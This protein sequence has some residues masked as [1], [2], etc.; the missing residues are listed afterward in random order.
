MGWPSL[1]SWNDVKR[2]ATNTYNSGVNA[3]RQT[4]QAVVNTGRAA[5][6]TV[7]SYARPVLR[8][9]ENLARNG[10]DIGRQFARNPEA[11]TR[12]LVSSA[13]RTV[14]EANNSFQREVR[15]LAGTARQK[16][17]EAEKVAADA[18]WQGTSWTSKKIGQGADV[19]RGQIKGNDIV[20]RN[21][22]GAVTALETNARFTVGAAGGVTR[23]VVGLATS[24]GS[25]GVTAA[26]YNL[27]SQ[28]RNEINGKIAGAA[29]KG[30]AQVADYG[31]S[32]A[33]DP[34]RLVSDLKSTASAA[35]N[36]T[37]DFVGGHL[38]RYDEAIKRGEGAETIGWDVGR[39]GSNFIPVG[40]AAKGA[41]GVGKVATSGLTNAL[42]R[43]AARESVEGAGKMAAR[44]LT[45]AGA[46]GAARETA[47][48]G[49]REA[50]ER[51]AATPLKASTEAR[52]AAEAKADALLKQ[53]EAG[54][55]TVR[56]SRAGN[57]NAQDLAAMSRQSG[58]EVALY[59]DLGSGERF[60]ALGNKTGV[61]IPENSR[62]IAHT[63]P[64]SGAAAVRASV[65]DEAALARLNQR[66][67]VIIND[68][69]DAA[70]R[71]RPTAK[72][73]E[74]ARSEAGDVRLHAPRAEL[75]A[76][77]L[78]SDYDSLPSI[79]GSG[80]HVKPK[81]PNWR[82]APNFENWQANGGKIIAEADGSYTFI[83]SDLAQVRY[84]PDG[85]PDFSPHL[86]HPSGVREVPIRQSGDNGA[87]FKAANEAAGH[88][89]WGRESPDNYTWHH[90]EDGS[91][92]QLVPRDIH[93]KTIGGFGHR[94]GASIHGGN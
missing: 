28:A 53:A 10:A 47:Q 91:L 69:G 86:N 56:V 25:L 75:P 89:E 54:G 49:A 34:S 9:A 41:V 6:N 87:D 85:F 13:R 29:Q 72:G 94:G 84:S 74:L 79:S 60:V 15:S 45:E 73:A 21:L 17:G 90:N 66:S 8:Q 5:V 32:V 20:S 62:L 46:K 26:E 93:D 48:V 65:A 76:R 12:Q 83:R 4:G 40:A 19:A 55:G 43:T 35:Y 11:T 59:R 36:G 63:Q 44:E 50:G 37:S 51:T 68:A 71:F 14:Q 81:G 27:S 77:R 88:P 82:Q 30:I 42:T 22:R 24:V 61:A 92:M 1:P 39:V 70:T 78:Q 31:R 38:K 23:E 67:S 57:L 18:I 64:G 7:K 33:A 2:A 52:A 3:V 16:L 80:A 58:R